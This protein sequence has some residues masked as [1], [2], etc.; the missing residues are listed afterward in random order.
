MSR[1]GIHLKV[2]SHSFINT[3]QNED[4]QSLGADLEQNVP[5]CRQTSFFRWRPAFKTFGQTFFR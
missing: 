3:R 2:V 4:E 1:S 5:R